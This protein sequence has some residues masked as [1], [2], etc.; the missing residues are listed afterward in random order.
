[1]NP[2]PDP[3]PDDG[4]G[5]NI[6]GSSSGY[7]RTP[8]PDPT[9]LTTQ[10]LYREVSSLKE[11]IEQRIAALSLATAEAD[12]AIRQSIK[13][14][15][16]A[17]NVLDREVQLRTD[18][19]FRLVEQQRVEQKADTK[20]A[21]DAALTAQKEAIGKTETATAYQLQELGKRFETAFDNLR[22]SDDEIKE[23]L[24]EVAT[25]ANA[26]GQ[27][28]QGQFDSRAIIG[29][30]IAAVASLIAIGAVVVSAIKP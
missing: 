27:Q 1:V 2:L 9:V 12:E 16:D 24:Q 8:I 13:E 17:R 14:A 15:I 25:I 28:K 4:S 11:L 19:Q 21:V 23:R 18:L 29:W 7:N 6:G 26:Y 20:N 22:R 10:A 3:S 30:A 5:P